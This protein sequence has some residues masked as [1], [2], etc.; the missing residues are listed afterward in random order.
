MWFY[1]TSISH[2]CRNKS[3]SWEWF[4][5]MFYFQWLHSQQQLTRRQ[6]WTESFNQPYLLQ[7]LTWWTPAHTAEFQDA[8]GWTNVGSDWDLPTPPGVGESR[9][10]LEPS[11]PA[12]AT[13]GNNRD[14]I[15]DCT[16]NTGFYRQPPACNQTQWS[17]NIWTPALPHRHPAS[18]PKCNC[19]IHLIFFPS[20]HRALYILMY[21]VWMSELRANADHSSILLVTT[22]NR[23]CLIWFSFHKSRLAPVLLFSM[24]PEAI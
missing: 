12:L 8:R 11:I 9:P 6:V 10:Q 21:L 13:W 19:F 15:N 1:F 5:F 24:Y 3:P 22:S 18:H 7:L 4:L 14:I 20:Q 16:S 23:I 2:S 17:S